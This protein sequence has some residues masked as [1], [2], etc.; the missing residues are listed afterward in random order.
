VETFPKKSVV[1]QLN[2]LLKA[3]FYLKW[4]TSFSNLHTSGPAQDPEHE[5]ERFIS[6]QNE[7]GKNSYTVEDAYEGDD[8]SEEQ[9]SSGCYIA[10]ATIPEGCSIDILKPL[11]QWRYTTMESTWLG[12]RAASHYRNTAPSIARK[13][14]HIPQTATFLRRLFVMPAVRMATMPKS[15]LRDTLL[16]CFFIAVNVVA[17][18]ASHL[19]R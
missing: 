8:E 1:R 3:I 9:N 4:C 10:T 12:K 17:W 5:G 13:I 2:H 7:H 11:K 16:W 15:V 19:H 14:A 18:L 6:V